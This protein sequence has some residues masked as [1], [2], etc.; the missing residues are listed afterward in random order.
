MVSYR[1]VV[2]SFR[3]KCGN[4]EADRNTASEGRKNEK[5]GIFTYRVCAAQY[6][7]APFHTKAAQK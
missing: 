4:M 1:F 6:S 2:L 7:Q 3:S 5:K